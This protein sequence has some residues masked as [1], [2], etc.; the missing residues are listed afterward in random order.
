MEDGQL[1]GQILRVLEDRMDALWHRLDRLEQ[2]LTTSAVKDAYTT[3]DVAKRLG[4]SEWTVRQ[5]CNKGQVEGA[6]KVHGRGRKGEWRIPHEALLKL[7]SE[8]PLPLTKT[9]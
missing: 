2:L 5:W 6:K 3:E 1:A 7:Q 8:G 9:S 4:R